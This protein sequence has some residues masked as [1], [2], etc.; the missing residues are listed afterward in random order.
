MFHGSNILCL[1][2]QGCT[3]WIIKVIMG[4]LQDSE[5]KE[6]TDL[7]QFIANALSDY[8]T[9]KM[10]R[11]HCEFFA[12]IF[13][14]HNML[15]R[16][17]I[18]QLVEK[19]GNARIEVLKRKAM[20]LLSRILKPVLSVKGKKS[21][22]EID[23][24]RQPTARALESH[25]EPLSA[26]LLLIVQKPPQKPAHK[27]FAFQFLSSCIDVLIVLYPQKPLSTI[28]DTKAL[29]E[30]LKTIVT[31][32]KGRLHNLITKIEGSLTRDMARIPVADEKAAHM[33][34]KTPGA[35]K[36]KSVDAEEII[37]MDIEP[38]PSKK[39]KKSL[40]VE[41]VVE[42]VIISHIE[43]DIAPTPS[44]KK[45][46]SVD[47]EKV[48]E[49][50]IEPTPSKKKKT[51]VDAEK[52]VEVEIEPTTSKKKKKSVEEENVVV[53]AEIVQIEQTPSK[54]KKQKE[55]TSPKTQETTSKKTKR[56]REEQ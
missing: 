47:A 3:L 5:T 18:G 35:K 15:G 42:S 26:V 36:K 2:L 37:E 41:K 21:G 50:A 33:K 13:K 29:L 25:L 46:M 22:A 32:G 34:L 44:K 4:N 9:S 45:K 49:V 17:S 14:R 38:T 39:K 19:C 8:F 6:D 16:S 56:C 23:E 40:D 10:S 1:G 48:V 52:V 28:L 27:L 30:G 11:L 43:T 12:E 20:E 24:V 51:M 31:P 54:K 53:E 7:V 55:R